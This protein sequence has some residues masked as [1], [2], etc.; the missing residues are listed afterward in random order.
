ME[1]QKYNVKKRRRNRKLNYNLFQPSTLFHAEN[2]HLPSLFQ[3]PR[4]TRS[5]SFIPVQRQSPPCALHLIHSHLL[6]HTSFFLYLL[7]CPI[8][9]PQAI[10]V[11][12]FCSYQKRKK[13]HKSKNNNNCKNNKSTSFDP[14]SILVLTCFSPSLLKNPILRTHFSLGNEITGLTALSPFG[15]S[16]FSTRS[17]VLPP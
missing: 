17:P 4:L 1:F 10:N 5:N 3:P 9:S 11:L 7:P 16:V 13:I 12:N 15:L 6:C 14:M 8:I 2:L